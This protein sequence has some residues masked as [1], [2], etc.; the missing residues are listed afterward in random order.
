MLR[1]DRNRRAYSIQRTASGGF[2]R[3][4]VR[5]AL[6]AACL[7][8]TIHAAP[9][10]TKAVVLVTV[11]G[12]RWQD[13]FGGID[14]RLM[15]EKGAGMAE[16]G[17]KELRERLMKDSPETRLEPPLPFFLKEFAP[18]GIVLCNANKRSSMRVTNAFRVICPS[19]SEFID[20]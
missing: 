16:P 14:P 5:F 3:H 19:N 7:A 11:D 1:R 18:R 20:R 2:A 15:N 9:H 13:L 6:Y 17:A 12:L 10:M 8:L 4:T